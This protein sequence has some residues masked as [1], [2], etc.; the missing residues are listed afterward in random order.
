M[1]EKAKR[2]EW[3]KYLLGGLLTILVLIVAFYQPILFGVA[4][5][6]AQQIA[7]SQEFSLRFKIHGS[8]FSNLYI[9]DLHIQPLPENRTLPLERVDAARIAVRYHLFSLLKKDFLNV[10]ELVELKDI[11]IVIRQVAPSQQQGPAASLRMPAIIPKKID[12]QNVN[13]IVRGEN[14]DLEVRKFAL[15]FQQGEE[16]YLACES[17]RIPALGTWNQ[18]RAGLRYNQGQLALTDFA[19][20]PIVAVNRLQVD[21]SG[22]E[23]G[24]F[25]LALDGKALDSAV[26]ANVT[27]KQPAEAPSIN[28]TLELT[29]LELGQIQKLSPIP[30]SGSISRIDVQLDGNLNLPRSFSGSI[31]VA[32]NDVRYQD[33]GID[34]ANLALI[35]DKGRGKIQELSVNAGPNKVRARGNFS[36]SETPNELLSGSSANIGLAAQVR[37][38]ERYIPDLNATTLVTGV[39]GLANGRAQLVFQTSVGGISIPKLVPGLAIS[40]VNTDLFAVAQLPLAEDPWK[41]LAAVVN[42]NVTNISYQDAHIREVRVAA[43]TMDTKTATA[44]LTLLTGESRAEVTANLPLP[45]PGAPFDPKQIAGHLRFNIASI[46]DFISQNEIAGNLTANGDVRFDHLQVNGAVRA[47]GNQLKY[48]RIILQS[49]ALD[50]AFR[51]QLAQVRDFRINF[52]PA[53]YIDLTGSAQLSD[54][55]PFQA[56]GQVN[57]KDVAALNEFLGDLGLR[58]G[59]SGGIN[60]NFTGT[61]DARNPTA[62]LQMSGNQLQ[63]RGFVVQG[64]DVEAIVEHATAE[65]QRCRISLDPNNY[66]DISGKVQFT[67]PNPYQA[68]GRIRLRDLGLF[69]ALLKSLGQ[70]QG[71][72]GALNLDFSGTGNRKNIAASLQVEGEKLKYLGLL[73]PNVKIEAAVEGGRADLRNC[74]V[75]INENDF[76]D[77]TGEVGLVAPYLYDARGA[78]TLRDLGVFDELLKNVG[79]PGDLRGSLSLNFSGKGDAKNPT[80]HLQILGD[81]LKY[82]GLVVQNV[83]IVSKVEN[84]LATIETGRLSLDA[85]NYIDATGN[86]QIAEPNSY[87]AHGTIALKNL[88]VF[89][90]LLRNLGQPGDLAGALEVDLSGKGTVKNPTAEFRIVGNQLKYRGLPVQSIDLQSKVQNRVANIQS[91]RIK[92]DADNYID[93]KGEAELTDPYA[94]KTNGAIELKNLAV[95]NELLKSIGQSAAV[96]GNVHVDWSGTGN[97][98]GAIPDAQLHVL[99]SQVKYRGLVIQSVDI[100]GDL[101]NRKLDLRNCKVVFNQDNFIDAKGNALLDEPYNYDADATIQFQDLGFLN[102][103][104]KSFGQDLGLGGKLSA[105]WTGKGPLQVQTGN[106]ELHGDQIRT[107]VAQRIKFDVVA[108][109]QG[110]N[111]EV[112]RLQVSSPFAD[113]DASMR[114]SPRLFEIPT[115]NIRKNGNTVTGSAKIPLNLQP[116]EKVP[117]DLDQPV[118]IKIQADKITLSSFQPDK[119]QVTGTIAF[120]LQVSQT[121]R[122]PLLQFMASVRDVRTTAV[123]NLSAAKGDLSV[124]VADKVLTVDGNIQQQDVHPLL[125]TGRVPLDVGQI[126]E[127]GHLPD[128]TPLQFALKWPDNNLR[129]IRK[130]IPHVKVVEGTTSVDVSINGTLKRPDLSGSIRASLSRFQ[131]RTDTVP[132]IADFSTTI[133]FRRDHVQLDQ[134]KGLAGGGLFGV[135]GAI[136]LTDGTNPKFDIGVTGNQ[137]L[138][139]RSD[140]IIVRANFN[141]AIRGPLSSGEVSG[142]VGITDSRFFKDIDILPLNLPGR[143]PPQPPTGAMP[144]IA[145]DTPPFN[146]WK[147][148]ISIRTDDAFLI[149]SNLARGR[150]TINLQA[151]GTG[152]APS[153]TGFVQVDRLVASLPFSKMEIDNGR[154]NFAQGGN[155]LDP[156]LSILG[157]STV[158]DYDVR[159]RI[160]GHVSNPTVLLDS[161]PP[162]A[163]GDILVLLAT[164]STTSQFE[165]NPSLLAGRATF[166]VLEQLYRKFFPSTSR[167]DGQKEPFIDRFSVNVGP[168]TRA[169]EQDIV[170]TF[171]LTKNWEIIGVFGTSSYQ[172]RLKYLVRFR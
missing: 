152:A 78:I 39:L 158:S 139:T 27:Y 154:I 33:Y 145:V 29:G 132:P 35:I 69:D 137:V 163:Q 165:Q 83:D 11:S 5:V 72:S 53:D 21:L 15:G 91:C 97:I 102:E 161:S 164:G 150:V 136:D 110:M 16:G 168:G 162:L 80:A 71:L 117:L 25:R 141:L 105:N 104:S 50:A 113:L 36:L 122:D 120:Q 167:A 98:R 100:D 85:D 160:F 129:F 26:A 109:Y 84:S 41:S 121:L 107:K 23:Q 143:P 13:L 73:I 46:T 42:G 106:L 4:Q 115:L 133:T 47:S 169:G 24:M 57:F 96:T 148:N 77:V 44:N 3:L 156:S 12:I 67:D 88:G 127:T 14:G 20:E 124:R 86:A 1:P 56:N 155:I 19:L 34:N 95:F 157:R 55:F 130:I 51:D 144:K 63:Y 60:I 22:S 116:G 112:P 17:L 9:E 147:F 61:G 111:A 103:L 79:Q 8:I 28:A 135:K 7:K 40:A 118:D 92:L 65:V 93:L 153:V 76:I 170:S 101:L 10:V 37:G 151:G 48:R 171:R 81:G 123:S 166:I 45:S 94:Y 142:T 62:Q 87:E 138:L 18:L 68:R 128:D 146:N 43:S 126:I 131:A 74:R 58:P 59:L 172:G 6:V 159:M 125:L 134:L 119:P 99:A 89:N 31:G 90:D 66:V 108:N 140:G 49:L 2:I 149:Q 52:D 38:P 75:T 54:P 64:A 70:P 32:A 30:I 82:R 114:L